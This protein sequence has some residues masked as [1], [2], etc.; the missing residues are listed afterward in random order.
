MRTSGTNQLTC[1]R[2]LFKAVFV[3]TYRAKKKPNKKNPQ[4]ALTLIISCHTF[5]EDFFHNVLELGTSKQFVCD[6]LKTCN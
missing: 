4:F 2:L 1:H 5:L 3:L 6:K